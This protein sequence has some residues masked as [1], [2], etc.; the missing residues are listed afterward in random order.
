METLAHR[1]EGHSI[2]QN[3]INQ[4]FQLPDGR[5]LGFAEYGAP[6]GYPVFLFHGTP[7]SRLWFEDDD[8]TA[9]ELSL[10]LIAVDRPGYGLSDSKKGRKILDFPADV[11]ALADHLGL[12]KFSVIGTSGGSVYAAACGYAFP[13]RVQKVVMVS[14]VAPF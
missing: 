12:D 9:H 7:G 2:A 5:N 8:P 4:T 14:A 6:D 10:R 11:A 3:R 1:S 13:E